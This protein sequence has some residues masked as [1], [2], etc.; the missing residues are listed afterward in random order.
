MASNFSSY[1]FFL[2]VIA[3]LTCL[4]EAQVRIKSK[5]TGL[6]FQY[7]GTNVE[8]AEPNDSEG[9]KWILECSQKGHFIINSNKQ[10]LAMD[11]KKGCK[12]GQSVM[13]YDKHSRQNQQFFINS[14]ATIGTACDANLILLVKDRNVEVAPRDNYFDF[15]IHFEIEPIE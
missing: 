14:D 5:K 9:Q 8:V 12:I 11:I 7:N 6:V 10:G 13:V 3:I 4:T 1:L 2:V 15:D